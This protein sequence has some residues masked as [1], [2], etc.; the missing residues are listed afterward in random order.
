MKLRQLSRRRFLQFSAG[1]VGF[2]ALAA[3]APAG[4]PAGSDG[5]AAP[6][7]EPTTVSLGLT[8]DASFQ[9]RQAEFN[10]ML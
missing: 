4:A 1:A 9:P 6:A 5:G 7:S 10:E 2:T 8:W 3:C